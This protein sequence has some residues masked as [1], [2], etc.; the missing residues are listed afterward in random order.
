[1]E[2]EPAMV[3]SVSHLKREDLEFNID[4]IVARLRIVGQLQERA[5]GRFNGD[6]LGFGPSP[7]AELR[8]PPIP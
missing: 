8:L 7:P 2:Y 1:V 5:Q 3:V 4:E 6:P